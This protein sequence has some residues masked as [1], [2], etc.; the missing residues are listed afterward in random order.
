MN[1]QLKRATRLALWLPIWS[2]GSPK[3]P[4]VGVGVPHLLQDEDLELEAGCG[5]SGSVSSLCKLPTTWVLS[6]KQGFA[7]INL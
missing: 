2:G 4:E 5:P 3:F 1:G 7:Y 6:D